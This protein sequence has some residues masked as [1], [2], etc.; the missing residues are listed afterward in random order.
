MMSL[1]VDAAGFLPDSEREQ[2]MADARE[3][4]RK[5]WQLEQEEL[6]K[7]QLKIKF[8]YWDGSGHPAVASVTVGETIADFLK[9]AR[10]TLEKDFPN[11]RHAAVS[12]LL[13]VAHNVLIPQACTFHRLIVGKAHNTKGEQLFDLEQQQQQQKLHTV[14]VLQRHWYES[15]KHIYPAN[16]WQMFDEDI[17]MK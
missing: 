13:L 11:L 1:R 16:C 10:L 14:K 17:H 3:S 5:Q 6:K 15:N 8:S 9:A 12:N 2:A 4:L 7:K